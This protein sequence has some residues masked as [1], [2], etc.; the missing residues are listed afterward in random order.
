[1]IADAGSGPGAAPAGP[2][3]SQGGTTWTAPGIGA[4]SAAEQRSPH[5]RDSAPRNTSGDCTVPGRRRGPLPASTST[6]LTLRS[7]LSRL[8]RPVTRARGRRRPDLD[9]LRQLMLIRTWASGGAPDGGGSPPAI[10][11]RSTA[12]SG[13]RVDALELRRRPRRLVDETRQRPGYLTGARPP[14]RRRGWRCQF[15]SFV[16][17][18]R[19][20]A[21]P[22]SSPVPTRSSQARTRAPLA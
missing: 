15:N 19:P 16:R 5:R 11:T 18:A 1:M 10:V 2:H 21:L 4:E 12:R 17:S 22:G 6:P 13:V 8:D 3:R 9:H 14:T 20:A 7:R